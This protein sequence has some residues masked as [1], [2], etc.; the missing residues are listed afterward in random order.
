MIGLGVDVGGLRKGLDVAVVDGRQLVRHERRCTVADVVE[1]AC[2]ETPD[3]IGVDAPC[4]CAAPGERSRPGERALSR[5]VCAIRFTPD[6][7]TVAGGG[8]Y[9]EWVRHGLE[10]H[11]ALRRA[12]P[13][14]PTVEV[15]P[16][17]SW[18]ILAGPRLTRSRASWSRDALAELGLAD[19]PERTSQDLRDAIA[20]AL[21]AQLSAE[22]RAA[23]YGPI[24][25]PLRSRP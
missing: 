22:G 13:G 20:A 6:A 24:V 4:D 8:P 16:T 23:S 7:R 17:A 2:E 3:A 15:F 12:L 25:V 10:L 5:E 19:V 11:R 14:V 1:I 9:Y 21:T 18:T